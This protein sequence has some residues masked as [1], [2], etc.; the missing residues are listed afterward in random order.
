MDSFELLGMHYVS[1]W[2]MNV[3]FTSQTNIPIVGKWGNLSQTPMNEAI[4]S[5]LYNET[6]RVLKRTPSRLTLVT[7]PYQ[8]QIPDFY[9]VVIDIDDLGS[10]TKDEKMAIEQQMAKEGYTV[11]SSPRGLHLHFRVRKNTK[12][13]ALTL[14]RENEEEKLERV[15]EGASLQKHLWTS[16][17]SKR[18][19]TLDKRFFTYSF[20][21]PDGKRFAKYDLKLL[22]EIEPP[23]VSLSDI[24][25]TLESFLGYKIVTYSPSE[26][27]SNIKIPDIKDFGMRIKPI[28]VDLEEFHARVH[29]FPLPV[30][31]A[32]ILY[33]YYKS[34]GAESLASDVLYINPSLMEN[35]EPISHGQRFLASAEFAL[36]VA[37]T[38]AFVKFSD[39]IK[40]LQYGVEDFPLDEGTPLDR[41][42]KYLFLFDE[43]T[44]EYVFPKYGGLG[45][46]RPT[47][48]C[49]NCFW[50]GDCNN[51][52]PTPWGHFRRFVQLISYGKNVQ[53]KYSKGIL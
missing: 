14:S 52:S 11:V 22:K 53:S 42:L 10:V 29:S 6:I 40:M 23:I 2:K 47:A 45:A 44:G 30:P 5:S 33:N 34:I 50:K 32:I 3:V 21:L 15:G 36:F 38:V 25:N 39:I 26:A 31:V 51:K 7:G 20:V 1:K 16:P 48:F 35:N 28:F 19:L 43:K 41:K 9:N 18:V 17:P 46:L 4:F 24:K 49:I 27:T 12:I 13:Y 8:E 37:H